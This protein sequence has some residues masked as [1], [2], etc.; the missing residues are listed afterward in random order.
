MKRVAR[1]R[2]RTIA[3]GALFIAL[4]GFMFYRFYWQAR[5]SVNT[6][7]AGHIEQLVTIFTEIDTKCGISEIKN[8]RNYI[9]FLTVKEFAGSQVGP[10]NL[11]ASDKWAGP[12][13]QENLTMQGKFYEIVKTHDGYFIVPGSGVKLGNGKVIGQDIVFDVTSDIESMTNNTVG[14]ESNGKPLAVRIHLQNSAASRAV[15][16]Q[17]NMIFERD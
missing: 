8:D 13:V 15:E 4:L 17:E 1:H 14:L 6:V 16:A 9:D 2:V 11:I 5:V 7:M 10:L 12:Y 3:I